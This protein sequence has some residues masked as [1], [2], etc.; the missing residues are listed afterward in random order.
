M[1]KVAKLHLYNFTTE[2]ELWVDADPDSTPLINRH[3][4][5]HIYALGSRDFFPLS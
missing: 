5:Q 4:V 3:H 1:F 2:Y